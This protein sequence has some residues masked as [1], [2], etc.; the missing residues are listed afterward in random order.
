[1][2]KVVEYKP[3]KGKSGFVVWRYLLRRDDISPA[4]W[5]SEGKA[6]MESLGLEIEVCL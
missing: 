1:M 4:P 3:V 6:M 2:Y 5:T